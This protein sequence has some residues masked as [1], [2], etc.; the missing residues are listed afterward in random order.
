MNYRVIGY[1]IGKILIIEAAMLLL[2]AFICIGYGEPFMKEFGI[3][4]LLLLLCGLP[5]GV[6]EG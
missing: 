1:V 2:P 3:P 5:L 4:I 6:K